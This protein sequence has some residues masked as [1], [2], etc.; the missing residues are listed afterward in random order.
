MIDN[1]EHQ[2]LIF[3]LAEEKFGVDIS[4]VREVLMP[5]TIKPMPQVPSFI[6]GVISLR[7]K[8]I[9]VLDLRK[10]FNIADADSEGGRIIIA[11]I[12]DFIVGLV[13][14]GVSE[15]LCILPDAVE[16]TPEVISSHMDDSYVRGVIHIGENVVTLLD[17]NKLLSSEE[18]KTLSSPEE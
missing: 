15:V 4:C 16:P 5:Q 3:N 1:L 14:D 12:G 13:V 10:R 8:I 6:E 11:K 2:V 9:A 18:K 17:S 7:D